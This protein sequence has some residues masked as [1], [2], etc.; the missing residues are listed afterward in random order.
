[1]SEIEWDDNRSGHAAA[2]EEEE[3]LVIRH[4]ETVDVDAAW[5]GIGYL[6]AARRVD[7]TR[8]RELVPRDLEDVDLER[9]P[10]ADE[11]DGRI[12]TLPD[13]SI[14]IP[15]YEEELVI[16]RRPVLRERVIVRKRTVTEQ[17]RVET[18]LRRER[19]ELDADDGVEVRGAEGLVSATA[20]AGGRS[21]VV[22]AAGPTET[23]PFF[24]TS[25]FLA[26]VAGVVALAVVALTADAVDGRLFWIL[27]SALVAAYALSRGFAK[28]GAPSRSHDPR[29]RT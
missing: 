10:A 22:D 1:V 5:E 16:T 11:D 23:R 6:R 12:E 4:E 24:L 26:A 18:E 28:S 2:D 8:V 27:A 17:Q 7:V 13:G 9:V 21:S 20:R 19:V 3:A 29:E 25:E 14:S 15:L